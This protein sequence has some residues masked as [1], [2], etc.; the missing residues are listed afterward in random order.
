MKALK[1]LAFSAAVGLGGLLATSCSEDILDI[2]PAANNTTDQFYQNEGQISQAVTAIYNGLLTL[3]SN[4]YWNMSELRSDNI[5]TNIALV[6]RDYSDI[7]NFSATSQTQQLQTTWTDLTQIVYRSNLLLQKIEPFTFARVNQFKAEA[8]FLRALAYFDLVRLWGPVP[9]A[10]TVLSATEAQQVPQAPIADVYQFIIEDLKFA[11]DNLPAAYTAADKGHATKWAAKALLG[12]VY[13]TGYGY[14]LRDASMLPLAKQQLLE[15]YAQEGAA[16]FSVAQNF[17]D[18]FKTANDNRYAVF[19][20][21]YISGGTGLGSQVPWEQGNTFPSFWSPFTAGGPDIQVPPAFFGANWPKIDR[22]KAA[23]IDSVIRNPTTG[24][25]VAGRP[26]FTKFLEKGTTAPQN[27]RD[28]PNNFLLI[29]FEDVVLMYAEVLNEESS[30]PVPALAVT[31]VN[32]IRTRSGILAYTNTSPERASKAAF[33]AAI[34]KE[35]RYE[36]V[37]E[38]Q[39]WFDLVRTGTALQTI[40]DFKRE[41]NVPLGRQ[42]DEHDLLFPLPLLELSI[43]PGFW[44]QNP[45]YN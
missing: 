16:T 3:P 4:V 18:L 43:N 37:V 25:L 32:R 26:Q 24:A 23:T 17:A 44:Q 1:L 13:L 33:R 42:L 39:R 10:E 36:F 5:L 7:S 22:R 6:A 40:M 31:L 21:Q 8:R 27:N 12:K 38:G 35:R 41:T 14:P 20:I 2:P 30:G 34:L 11:A 19:E 9:I 29:R 45:G 28:Y 15:V